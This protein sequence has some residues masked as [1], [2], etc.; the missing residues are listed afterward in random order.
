MAGTSIAFSIDGLKFNGNLIVVFLKI[1]F[2]TSICRG[3]EEK[4]F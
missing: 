2:L 1:E 4:N 3:L